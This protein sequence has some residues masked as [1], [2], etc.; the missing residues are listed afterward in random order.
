M[1]D[2]HEGFNQHL[3]HFLH[4]SAH[5]F[6]IGI[7]FPSK[8]KYFLLLFYYWYP[9]AALFLSDSLCFMPGLNL[10]KL[11]F[12]GLTAWCAWMELRFG[13]GQ[14]GCQLENAAS[15]KGELQKAPLPG[16][17][18]ALW[19][20]T[21]SNSVLKWSIQLK[22]QLQQNTFLELSKKLLK[23]SSSKNKTCLF[24]KLKAKKYFLVKGSI[25]AQELLKTIWH[26]DIFPCSCDPHA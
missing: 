14:W 7:I 12:T 17:P 21:A 26:S 9:V 2:S 6:W 22:S 8:R 25:F 3:P 23:D 5:F 1:H 19:V 15:G 20:E 11:L 10:N 16:E 4:Y 13:T 24:L 18:Q